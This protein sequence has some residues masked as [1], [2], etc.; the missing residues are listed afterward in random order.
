M[1]KNKE[2]LYVL[3]DIML[4]DTIEKEQKDKIL[5]LVLKFEGKTDKL[6]ELLEKFLKAKNFVWL[7]QSLK[8]KKELS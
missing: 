1:K 8:Q 4:S 6:I 5:D 3:K 2:L 7:N